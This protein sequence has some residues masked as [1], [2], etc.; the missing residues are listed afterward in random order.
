LQV[1]R[2]GEVDSDFSAANSLGD[3]DPAEDRDRRQQRLAEP[4]VSRCGALVVPGQRAASGGNR[5]KEDADPD[6]SED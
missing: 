4:D 6:E 2:P 3:L 5:R 1:D